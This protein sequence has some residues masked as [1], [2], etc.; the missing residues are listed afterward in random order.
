MHKSTQLNGQI[1]LSDLFKKELSITPQF[2]KGQPVFFRSLDVV[3]EGI[4]ESSWLCDFKDENPYFGYDALL[5]QGFHRTFW[6]GDIG[7]TAFFDKR[8]AEKAAREAEK[9]L[10]KYFP[11]A[12]DMDEIIKSLGWNIRF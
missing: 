2:Q 7:R 6:D 11:S 9:G 5:I 12:S 4:V 1:G 8:S 10:K 3:L